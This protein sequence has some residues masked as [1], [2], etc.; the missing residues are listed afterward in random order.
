MAAKSSKGITIEMTKGGAT[1]T[2]LTATAATKAAPCVVSVADVTGLVEGQLVKLT[3]SATGLSE[4]DGKTFVI[5]SIDTTAN[6]FTLVGSDTTA[7]TGT[8]AA[9]T[10]GFEV[11][12]TAAVVGL[13]LSSIGFNPESPQTI[14]VGTYCSPSASIPGAATGAG[15][16]DMAGYVDVTSADYKE[17]LAAEADGKQRIVKIKLPDNG[18]IT[19]PVV[20][21]AMNWDLPLEGAVSWS[22]SG[23]LGARAIHLF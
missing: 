6:T 7:S 10:D 22:A 21:S 15:S 18:Y 9:G 17:L 12:G 5:G 4:V 3:S 20:F 11:Y 1:T 19:F 2:K 8:F 13:C 14:S 23:T 16:V